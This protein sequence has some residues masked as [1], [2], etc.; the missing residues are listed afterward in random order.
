MVMIIVLLCGAV[1]GATILLTAVPL[2]RY[3]YYVRRDNRINNYGFRV[4]CG[5]GR[6]L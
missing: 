5:A 2:I 4:V 6:T 3:D 1:P